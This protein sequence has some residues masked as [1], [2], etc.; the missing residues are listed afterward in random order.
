VTAAQNA[1]RFSN[2]A[3]TAIRPSEKILA[4]V[5]IYRVR[6]LREVEFVPFYGTEINP[7]SFVAV[8]G[9]KDYRK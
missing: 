9:Y 5:M 2:C 7:F 3:G 1:W 6:D 4:F 8:Y